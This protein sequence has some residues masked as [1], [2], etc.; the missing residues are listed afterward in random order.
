MNIEDKF[1]KL[2]AQIY[3]VK[4]DKWVKNL[5]TYFYIM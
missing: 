5:L 4:W 1:S 3:R 2:G